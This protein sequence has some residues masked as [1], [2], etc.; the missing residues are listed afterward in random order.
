MYVCVLQWTRDTIPSLLY[1]AEYFFDVEIYDQT[2]SDDGRAR[3]QSGH[4]T[5]VTPGCAVFADDS[6]R[7]CS[8]L[9]PPPQL[10]RA[11][12]FKS[13]QIQSNMDF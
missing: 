3:R 12:E 10:Q 7:R 11:S 5:L 9:R 6:F 8:H 13:N 4:V 2:S 1:N